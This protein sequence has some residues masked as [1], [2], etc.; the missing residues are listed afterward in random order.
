MTS[1]RSRLRALLALAAA[2]ALTSACTSLAA[3]AAAPAIDDTRALANLAHCYVE[4]VDAIGA[5]KVDAGAAIWKQCFSD[6]VAFSMSF[7][8]SY[9]VA[10]PSE[11]C[12]LPAVMPGLA[13]RVAMA[14]GTYE[15]AGYVAT[16]H[17]VTT[18]GI[19]QSSADS[20][21]LK[22]H[23]QAWHFRKDGTVVL[24]LGT[25]EVQAKKTGAGWRIVDE[26]L[27]SPLRAVIP[28]AE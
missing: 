1:P 19:E 8:P 4:G 27:E 26:K 20:A 13:K 5:G 12:P 25:W 28:K 21:R 15:R 18:L 17:H 3:P 7:G 14:R 23:L 2:C 22:G 11:K 16:S 10:C 9:S 6:D 24:G